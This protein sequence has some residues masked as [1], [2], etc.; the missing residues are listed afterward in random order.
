MGITHAQSRDRAQRGLQLRATGATWQHV[1]DQLGYRSR[2]AA[3]LAVR[4]YLDAHQ[5]DPDA[6]R[7]VTS[8]TLRLLTSTLFNQLATARAAGDSDSVVR[9]SKE[10]RSIGAESSKLNGLY[11]PVE[12][13]LAVTVTQS[14]REEI[15]KA[16]RATLSALPAIEGEVVE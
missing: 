4:R 13:S 9:I 10:I 16:R 12:H 2:Q 6:E 14:P 5:P 1:A 7:G 3:Q 11:R 15:E 8:E